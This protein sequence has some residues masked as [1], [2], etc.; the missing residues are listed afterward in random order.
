MDQNNN[1]QKY[2]ILDTNVIQYLK[3][4]NIS[5]EIEKYLQELVDIGF[6]LCISDIT[7]C[8]HISGLD[9]VKESQ[10]NIIESFDYFPLTIAILRTAGRL[11]NLYKKEKVQEEKSDLADRLIAATAIINGNP[12]LT[13]NISDFPRPFFT[14]VSEKHLFYKNKGRTVMQVV[15]VLQ[16]NMK[17]ILQKFLEAGYDGL[18]NEQELSDIRKF[19]EG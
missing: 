15:Q 4:E 6:S 7:R 14:E 5:V 16:P 10:S 19:I 12:I 17:V 9:A 2:I 11:R 18:F 1:I 8:E 3:S 13:A